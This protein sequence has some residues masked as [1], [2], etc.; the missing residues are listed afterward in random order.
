MVEFLKKTCSTFGWHK[1][2][3][4]FLN[5][6]NN[7]PRAAYAFTV[8]DS[9]PKNDVFPYE[10][11]DVFY[12]GQSGG[13]GDD[14][15]IDCKMKN[16]R[17]PKCFTTFHKRMKAHRRMNGKITEFISEQFFLKG[18]IYIF[19]AQPKN[20]IKFVKAWLL[21]VESDMIYEYSSLYNMIPYLNQAHKSNEKIISKL[22]KHTHTQ[23]LLQR[24][25][26]S[27]TLEQFLI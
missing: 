12:I 26:E 7:I 25:K 20:E 1:F 17:K 24:R 10:I 3:D 9:M 23:K 22:Y 16:G 2:D 11:E 4:S 19:V 27:T 13:H 8:A 15:T 18:Q 21:K 6:S 5:I 14:V